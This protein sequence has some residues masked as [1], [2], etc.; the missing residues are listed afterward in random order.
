MVLVQSGVLEVLARAPGAEA[1]VVDLPAVCALGRA[2][3]VGHPL[4]RRLR[5]VAA[6]ARHDPLP[7][8]A[9]MVLFKAVRHDWPEAGASGLIDRAVALLAPGGSVALCERGPLRPDDPRPGFLRAG[10]C[11]LSPSSAQRASMP[12]G[13][14]STALMSR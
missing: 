11:I 8:P 14:G 4:A 7:G 12:N 9:D 5:I 6:D 3:V 10:D 13:C 1:V 2:H